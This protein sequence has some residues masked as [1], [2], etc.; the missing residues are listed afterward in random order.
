MRNFKVMWS[1]IVLWGMLATSAGQAADG[2][3]LITQ[4]NAIAGGIDGRGRG[5]ISNHSL[6]AGQIQI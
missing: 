6:E 4:T 3:I 2:E 5:G 1:A